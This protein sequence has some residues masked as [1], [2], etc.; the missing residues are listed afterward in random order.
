[1]LVHWPCSSL[2]DTVST[3]RALEPLVYSGVARAIGI[4]NFNASAI[5]ALLPRVSV[6]PVVNQCGFSIAGHDESTSLWG[7]E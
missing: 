7:R 1:M 6:R 4:S 2:D 5:E 3:Y